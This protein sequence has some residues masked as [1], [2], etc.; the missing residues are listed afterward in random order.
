MR[1]L[2]AIFF[3]LSFSATISAQNIEPKK[4]VSQQKGQQT[5]VLKIKKNVSLG[6]LQ[7]KL[8]AM[9]KEGRI[10][11]KQAHPQPIRKNK[12]I[13]ESSFG[14]DRVYKIKVPEN[15]EVNTI[16]K[17]LENIESLEYVEQYHQ[18]ELLYLPND[19]EANPTTGRQNHLDLIKA[20]DAW[21]VE[22]GDSSIIIGV[23][24]TGV[25]LNH[26]DLRE[27]MF[28]NEADPINGV[29]DDN[30]GYIDNY[31]GW[32][33]ADEDNDPTDVHNHG[34]QVSG[35][36]AARTNNSKGVAGMGFNS[37]FMPIK[38]YTNV[39]TSFYDGYNAILYAAAKG[40]KVI[41]LSWGS[42][43]S[44]SKYVEDIINTVVLDMD[45]VIVAAAGNSNLKEEYYP[46]SYEYVLS[47]G[48]IQKDVNPDEKS[49][50]STYSPYIDISAPGQ[51]VY[52]TSG[53]GYSGSS[54]T[55]VA[56]PGVA[57][58]A[59]L[60]RARF[61]ELNALQVME[62]LR[63]TSDDIYHIGNNSLYYEMLGKGRLNMYQALI[64]STS[65]AVRFRNMTYQNE[66]GK[67]ASYGDTVSISGEFVNY[68]EEVYDLK[69]TL[70]IE[71][72]YIE[73]ID[74]VNNYSLLPT[75][76]PNAGNYKIFIKPTLPPG[77]VLRFRL[78]FEG[79]GYKDYQY[80]DIKTLPDY[81][82]VDNGT[83]AM[84]IGSNGNLG[85]NSDQFTDGTGIT[86]NN[87][88]LLDFMSLI[89]AKDEEIVS[90]NMFNSYY[91][92]KREKDFEI[93]KSIKVIQNDED[94][95]KA[96][97]SF[98][99]F[100]I[101][102]SLG[103]HIDQSLSGYKSGSNKDFLLLDYR[104]SNKSG[105]KH[106]SLKIGMYMDWDIVDSMKNHSGYDPDFNLGYVYYPERN[107][108]AGLALLSE[109]NASFNPVSL[110]DDNWNFV[111]G[112]AITEEEKF[113]LLLHNSVSEIGP[114]N[115]AATLATTLYG[116]EDQKEVNV[117]FLVTAG[118]SVEELRNNI[119]EAII[120]KPF[121]AVANIDVCEGES[122]NFDPALDKEVSYYS[123]SLFTNLIGEGMLLS[124][125]SP[126]H[127]KNIYM[128][129]GEAIFYE[130]YKAKVIVRD[131]V[132]AEFSLPQ[133]SLY[134]GENAENDIHL[135]TETPCVNK[136]QWSI[137]DTV[138]SDIPDP[139]ITFD[140]GGTYDIKLKVWNYE[141]ESDSVSHTLVVEYLTKVEENE[142]I[143]VNLFPNP[144]SKTLNITGLETNSQTD[145]TIYDQPGR[146]A[147]Y[148][149]LIVKNTPL[150]LNLST[151][152]PGLY[153]IKIE[154]KKA[155]LTRKIMVK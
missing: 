2:V 120:R 28:L 32:D 24:D 69:V 108:Y 60:V 1:I 44:Y 86:Y 20:Y 3:V 142:K 155:N 66:I 124:L 39:G 83:L 135:V 31:Y 79:K 118:A 7:K 147:F 5:I 40:C 150:E 52:T 149:S 119:K 84:T 38:I 62:R 29:D 129:T 49:P 109:Q 34:T 95:V 22:K 63:V 94:F 77:E 122:I 6:E 91:T 154:T 136:W 58:A 43:G 73:M 121:V 153:I 23:L 148:N 15:I 30:D 110:Y 92:L 133:D 97:S 127:Y 41:N 25:N 67:I 125:N 19:T 27:N 105:G 48:N 80:F 102:N 70:S 9:T 11:I 107:I 13:I 138:V 88:Y 64:D 141:N 128:K 144:V 18:M 87:E 145:I 26:E 103:L 36:A 111:F 104:I 72:P 74:S 139:V 65:S 78:G 55:S 17:R 54:G 98:S 93:E 35:I 101:T 56:S 33:F 12:K 90:D 59:A 123:D 51:N 116:I 71:S 115:I 14:L 143:A 134:L 76:T 81:F 114:K 50:G 42:V 140:Q 113:S 16:I 46:A 146:V 137:N 89:I 47:V 57:G 61:P 112:S 106:D 130:K 96:S 68:L 152:T 132:T 21:E 117:Q 151:L 82:T 4:P 10:S 99:D 85:Y 100:G 53:N 131:D 126:I 75:L 8:N 45:V 37:K